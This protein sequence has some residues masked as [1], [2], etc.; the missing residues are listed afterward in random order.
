MAERVSGRQNNV[1]PRGGGP[2]RARR[3]KLVTDR[4][5]KKKNATFA[6]LETNGRA[7]ETKK[8]PV[9]KTSNAVGFRRFVTVSLWKLQLSVMETH[10]VALFP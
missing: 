3:P 2:S 10:S 6:S 8:E 5:L 4:W 7:T 9:L 1:K